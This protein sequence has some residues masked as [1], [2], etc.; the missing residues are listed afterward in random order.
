MLK[1]LEPLHNIYSYS[2]LRAS[3][4]IVVF[5]HLYS[6]SAEHICL[7]HLFVHEIRE[8]Q[9]RNPPVFATL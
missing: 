5:C 6:F 3:V 7:Y 1:I 8:N 9:Q 2:T 4:Y